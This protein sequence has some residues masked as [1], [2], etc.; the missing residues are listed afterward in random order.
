MDGNLKDIISHIMLPVN[1]GHIC[2]S[3]PCYFLKGGRKIMTPHFFWRDLLAIVK[4][5]FF[6][7]P[8]PWKLFCAL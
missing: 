3:S 5:F 2:L 1:A 6:F 8:R 4:L 7:K